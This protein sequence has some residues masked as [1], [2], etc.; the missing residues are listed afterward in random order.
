MFFRIFLILSFYT[1]SYF[2]I[3]YVKYKGYY[4]NQE[5]KQFF[6]I[7]ITSTFLSSFI[8]GKFGKVFSKEF[9]NS[10]KTLIKAFVL[11]IGII[12]FIVN[13][14]QELTESRLLIIGSLTLG[15]LFEFIYIVL[16]SKFDHRT[17]EKQAFS[18]SVVFLVIEFI[19]LTWITF[20][21]LFNY[22]FPDYSSKQK[23]LFIIILYTIWFVSSSISR[24][25]DISKGTNLSRII[26][27]HLSSYILLFLIVSS[28]LF[29]LALPIEIKKIVLYN[30]V[31]FSF[32]SFFAVILFYLY[33]SKPKTDSINYNI[34]NSTE[35]PE[36]VEFKGEINHF[37]DKPSIL[38]SQSG[39]FLKDQLK[40]VYLKNFPKEHEFVE[41]N[42]ELENYNISECVILRSADM[43]NIEVIPDSSIVLYMNLHELNDFRSLN[44]YL[45]RINKSLKE[46]GYFVG[47]FQSNQLKYEMFHFKY[48]FYLANFYYSMDFLW[49]RV[50]PKLPI[51]KI[52]YAIISKGRNRA[53]SMAEGLGRLYYCGFK[54]KNIQMINNHL[55]F[56]AKKDKEP[57][58]DTSPSYGLFFKMRRVGQFGKPIYVYKLRSMHPYS[59]YIQKFVYDNFSLKE[60]GKFEN[61]FRITS[62]GRLARKL[63]IDEL[64][65]LI[66][67][68]KGELKLVGIRPLS[69]HYLSLYDSKFVEFR[70]QF[71]PGLIPPFYADMPKNLDEIQESERKYLEN[72]SG[73]GFKTDF[74]YLLKAFNNIIFKNARSA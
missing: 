1:L 28:M 29:L 30:L 50:F 41:K 8:L 36:E 31:I 51:L 33:R 64:P 49:K 24:H 21:S 66:N 43:Y 48:P 70:N 71:K 57:S 18:F 27:N 74:K 42:L 9:V 59:E 32:W 63:W 25:S 6:I 39:L 15:F 10:S 20:Y 69:F 13:F 35:F 44:E 55:Y 38:S 5:L 53:L 26:W 45:I 54:V 40:S 14:Q 4:F 56:I 7:Y 11:N 72:Y 65:M 68:I 62:W 37:E 47:R 46:N 22:E 61:D 73:N 17:K 16:N 12:T 23:I 67:L 52:A 3:N 2:L 60:G 19:I 34:L 58:V